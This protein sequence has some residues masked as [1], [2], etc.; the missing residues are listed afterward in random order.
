MAEPIQRKLRG[1]AHLFREVGPRRFLLA[2]C[3]RLLLRVRIFFRGGGRTVSIDGCRFP[4]RDLPNNMM[5]LA[6]LDGS[7]E[8]PE[9]SAVR[10]YIQPNWGVVE[11]GACIGVISCVTNKL[12]SNP[13]AHVVVEINPLVLPHLK[14][15]REANACSFKILHAA[16]AYGEEQVSFRPH[17]EFWGN[18]LRQGGSRPPVTV[19]VTQLRRIIDEEGFA[20]FAVICDVEGQQLELLDHELDTLRKASLIIMELH[21]HM[22]GQQ[23]AEK[24]LTTLVEQGF[25]LERE[26]A[27]LAVFRKAPAA[28]TID[29]RETAVA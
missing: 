27:N 20:E 15:N 21:P 25:R 13:S 28:V 22:V 24:I 29:S 19:P 26:A 7:Y 9:R 1:A 10:K 18:F 12:L 16:V 2:V 4:L 3:A 11:L 5:K 6:L 8:A 17:L 14:A 23:N